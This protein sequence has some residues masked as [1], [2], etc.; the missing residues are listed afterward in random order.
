MGV[1]GSVVLLRND[2]SNISTLHP[3]TFIGGG[4]KNVLQ[5]GT[6]IVW[7]IDLYGKRVK[8]NVSVGTFTCTHTLQ[9]HAY[10]LTH[11]H[12]SS[13]VIWFPCRRDMNPINS[14]S[15]S[16]EKHFHE[17]KLLLDFVSVSSAAAIWRWLRDERLKAAPQCRMA[18]FFFFTCR[19]CDVFFNT[20][21]P[22]IIMNTCTVF[23]QNK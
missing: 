18:L 8:M 5:R 2:T 13:A 1:N 11:I 20:Q 16:I 21:A 14:G 19:T 6:V 12:T 9:I 4:K 15:G 7:L 23:K 17:G 3:L 10:A 22:P